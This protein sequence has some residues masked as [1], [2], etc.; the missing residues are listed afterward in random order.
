MRR[1]STIVLAAVTGL[2]VFVPTQAH[3][4]SYVRPDPANDV[5]SSKDDG[6]LVRTPSRV[7]GDV[8][9]SGVSYAGRRITVAMGFAEL[10]QTTELTGHLF[11]LRTNK[12]KVR[13]VTVI[14]QPG[15][16][17]GTA[18]M[19]KSS[20]RKVK[21]R[22]G[23]RLDYVADRVTVSIPRRCVG[24][25]RW[26]KVGMAEVTFEGDVTFVDDA[27]TNARLDG[28]PVYGPVVRR[29]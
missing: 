15:S 26:V 9:T 29:R 21:C 27:M 17:G 24:S 2:A 13:E 23:T 16:W 28:N 7:E 10:T 19:Q 18:I 22:M 20:G 14:A 12:G 8:L 11:R 25:P 4:G 6:P 1:L 3:A 5:L